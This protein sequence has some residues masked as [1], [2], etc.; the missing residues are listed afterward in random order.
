MYSVPTPSAP[1]EVALAWRDI[2]KLVILYQNKAVTTFFFL[3]RDGNKFVH[4]QEWQS[5]T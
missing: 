2:A 5:L 3:I 4:V 1:P